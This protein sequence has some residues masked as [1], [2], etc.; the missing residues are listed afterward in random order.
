VLKSGKELQ[1]DNSIIQDEARTVKQITLIEESNT[2]RLLE[3]NQQVNNDC[4]ELKRYVSTN[5]SGFIGYFDD[6]PLDN[7]IDNIFHVQINRVLNGNETVWLEY[8]LSGVEDYTGIA[9]SI[10]DQLSIGGYIVKK[11]NEW[12]K[13]REQLNPSD[14]KK[15]DNVIRFTL[16][17]NADYGFQVKNLAIYVE[18]DTE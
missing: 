8:E 16:P 15:G 2:K 9:H 18:P 7:P 14:I 11:S 1:A 6:K 17:E 12:K 4:L 13:Q 3:S 10:N 5:K